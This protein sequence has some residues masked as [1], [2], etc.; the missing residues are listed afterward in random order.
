MTHN[1]TIE[2]YNQKLVNDRINI[3]II[4]YVKA[5]NDI[6]YKINISFI[7]EL[8]ELVNRDDCCIHHEMLI[9]Y[10]ICKTTGGS[11]DIKRL[12]NQYNFI[13]NEDYHLSNVAEVRP[14]GG[15]VIK[16][17]YYLHPDTFKFC[18]MRAKNTKKYATY[19][20]L[21]EKC[22]K[23]YSDYQILLKDT[24]VIKL[25]DKIKE[26]KIIIKE[27]DDKIVSLENKIDKVLENNNQL[28]NDNKKLLES[29]DRVLEDNKK[30]LDKLDD[31]NNKLEDIQDELSEVKDELRDTTIK[32]DLSLED[33]VPKTKSIQ[34][35]EYFVLLQTTNN[36]EK[37]KYY[38][39]RGQ[40]RYVDR[41]I[42]TMNST[43]QVI[44]S[45]ECIP[46]ATNL[47]SRIK[48]QMKD[49]LD[50][51]NNK[52]NIISIDHNG[53]VD[54]IDQIYQQKNHV[55]MN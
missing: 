22:I 26:N 27:K 11:K 35:R 24:Y 38:V 48:E 54:K 17:T 13:E 42:E 46:N 14:Q 33:R 8:L 39:L 18:L 50:I 1:S 45:Y 20:L 31:A 34:I 30:L 43:Y 36:R 10:K 41:K 7:G 55:I 32:L 3:S 16:C 52:L 28:L 6:K 47:F 51:C 53:F 37:Y 19:Y 9:K 25:K 40:K 15:T 49:K 29:N 23:H 5:V 21:L 44:K 4:D 2:E 12:L